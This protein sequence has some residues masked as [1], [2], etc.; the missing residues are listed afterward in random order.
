MREKLAIAAGVVII[1][2][3]A[4]F[5][6]P[7]QKSAAPAGPATAVVQ[8]SAG[9]LQGYSQGGLNVYLGIPYAEPPTGSRRFRAPQ[10]RQPWQ[11]TF[12]AYQ[13][14]A[15]CPQVYDS[16]EVD[17]PHEDLNNENCLTL[18]IWAPAQAAA[19][20][21]VMVFI[22]GGGFVEGSSKERFYHGEALAGQGD[23]LVVTFNYR[24]GLLGWL[25]F[26]A[27]AG[28]DYAA[29]ADVG[30]QDQLL[31]LQ[32]V[33]DNIAAFGGDP[34]NV[35][36]FGESAGGGSIKALL[37]LEKPQA[38]FRRA[39]VMSGSPLHSAENT[40]A[41]ASLIKKETGVPWPI[42]WQNLPPQAVLYIQKQLL[43][44]VGSPLSDLLFAPTYGAAYPV[45][46][47]P[48]AAAQAGRTAGIDLMIGTM[49]DELT[50]WSFYD[51]PTS[52]I[53]G[54][55]VKDNL[56]TQV[57]PKVEPKIQ[58]LYNLY[59]QNPQRAG[60]SEG[61]I[62]LALGDDYAFRVEALQLAEAQSKLGRTY[63]YRVDYPVNLPDQPCQDK[64]SPHGSE[65]PFVFGRQAE[66]TG[67]K[68]IGL[69]RDDTEK[70]G[71][72]QLSALMMGAWSSFAKTGDP[73]GGAL[74]DWPAFDPAS[75][76][77]MLFNLQ[78][79]VVNKP[80]FAEYQAMSTFMQTFSVFDALK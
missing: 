23:V 45:K 65:L 3:L 68:F 64:R 60:R 79:Q 63:V 11:E 40:R 12:N 2:L 7:A 26:S 16:V 78:P 57:D 50:Y 53:C 71:R 55:T 27:F 21:A 59:S 80:F 38:Y 35:T 29:S 44:A 37:G 75:Q 20:R 31:A 76:P 28:T 56:F 8:T 41:I 70:A 9:P 30:L 18:N 61:Q 42:A 58:E 49:A 10:P 14:G 32:W 4:W 69:P 48:T 19:P 6:W 52:K 36:V 17:D 66:A 1:F 25:D 51:T 39:I 13:F 33:Q 54:Q 34:A 24:L 46:S 5:F 67:F 22:H 15:F 77:T 43:D 73:N 74:P 72:D 47:G 62:I